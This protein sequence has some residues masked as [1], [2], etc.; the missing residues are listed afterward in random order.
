MRAM[1][2]MK[3]MKMPPA[4]M[5]PAMKAMKSMK[6]M[7]RRAVRMKPGERVGRRYCRIDGE[8]VEH[9]GSRYA[10]GSR[11]KRQYITKDEQIFKLRAKYE[12]LVG[13]FAPCMEE[14]IARRAEVEALNAK[15]AKFNALNTRITNIALGEEE[16]GTDS[17]R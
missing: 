14:L 13:K 5:K 2:S 8:V 7:K 9:K 11:R 12:L 17:R 3:A 4:R 15:I 10:P 1:K 16:S 6:S